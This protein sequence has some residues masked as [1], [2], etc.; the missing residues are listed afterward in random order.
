MRS[1]PRPPTA[2]SPAAPTT[3][4]LSTTGARLAGHFEQP[5][6][7]VDAVAGGGDVLVRLRPEAGDDHR[8]VM[9]ADPHA[10]GRRAAIRDRAEPGG[11]RAR[12]A[13]SPPR[14]RA[15]ASLRSGAGRPNT[16]MAPS[17]MKE[18]TS[19]HARVAS[20][21][22][23]R[24]QALEQGA[25]PLGAEAL[26]QAGE[27]GEVEEQDAAP[28]AARARRGSPGSAARRSARARG[29]KR[30]RASR[31]VLSRRSTALVEPEPRQDVGDRRRHHAGDRPRSC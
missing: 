15:R 5:A 11:A 4:A 17:P 22:M 2:G 16:I 20:S 24:V 28:P 29:W 3:S 7:D 19:P 12:R 31:A 1:V 30:R 6:R 14:W 25:G 21:S 10:Q 26:A 27:A 23:M 9:G 8:S 18:M 13:R